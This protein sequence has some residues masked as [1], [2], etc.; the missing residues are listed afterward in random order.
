MR[1]DGDW[2]WLDELLLD[3]DG[4]NCSPGKPE[5]LICMHKYIT[6]K[7]YFKFLNIQSH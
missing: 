3:F 7:V 6:L 5:T 4:C 1:D 2:G